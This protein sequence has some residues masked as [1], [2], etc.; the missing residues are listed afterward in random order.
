MSDVN[1]NAYS[2]VIDAI[3]KAMVKASAGYDIPA[4]AK[5]TK[6]KVWEEEAPPKGT[7]YHYPN[8]YNHQILSIAAAPAPHKIAVQI[9][10]QGLQTQMV[11]RYAIKNEPMDKVLGYAANELEGYMRT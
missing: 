5:L 2:G 4:F 7:L 11:V 6:L 8:P 1:Q 10:R 3:T 9:Y